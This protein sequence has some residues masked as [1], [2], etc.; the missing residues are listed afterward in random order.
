M[1]KGQI[2][3]VVL[4]VWMKDKEY[5]DLKKSDCFA[6]FIT[7]LLETCIFLG[8][9]WYFLGGFAF[10]ISLHFYFKFIKIK[11]GESESQ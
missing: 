1:G 9:G 7:S 4:E 3:G 10:C 5:W 6:W 11:K 8:W 2:Y